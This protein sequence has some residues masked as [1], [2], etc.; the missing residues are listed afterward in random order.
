MKKIKKVLS[1]LLAVTLVFSSSAFNG[2]RVLAATTAT[3]NFYLDGELV[4]SETISDDIDTISIDSFTKPTTIEEEGEFTEGN[5][6][7]TVNSSV[8]VEDDT[9]W[10]PTG[11]SYYCLT[12]IGDDNELAYGDYSFSFCHRYIWNSPGT[13]TYTFVIATDSDGTGAVTIGDSTQISNWYSSLTEATGSGTISSDDVSDLSEYKYIG[14]Y[15]ATTNTYGIGGTSNNQTTTVQDLSCTFTMSETGS[16]E[17]SSEADEITVA[18]DADDYVFNYYYTTVSGDPITATA[19]Y[20]LNGTYLGSSDDDVQETYAGRTVTFTVPESLEYATFDHYTLDDTNYDEYTDTFEDLE[21]SITVYY[22]YTLEKCDVTVNYYMIDSDETETLISSEILSGLPGTYISVNIPQT[23]DDAKFAYY[24]IDGGDEITEYSTSVLVT[25]ENV[26]NYYFYN[27]YEVE[28]VN[29]QFELNSTYAWGYDITQ[30]DDAGYIFT[31]VNV[32]E[33]DPIATEVISIWNNDSDTYDYSLTYDIEDL[34]A[35]TYEVTI[36][37]Y[38]SVTS[39]STFTVT[40]ADETESAEISPEG[41]DDYYDDNWQSETITFTISEAGTVTISLSGTLATGD[42]L[43]VSGIEVWKIDAPLSAYEDVAEEYEI[44]Y[45][46]STFYN[47]DLDAYNAAADEAA[48]A[49]SGDTDTETTDISVSAS[50]SGGYN[51]QT[52]YYLLDEI[53]ETLTAGT[54]DYTYSYARVWN[55][56]TIQ[57]V[58]ATDSTGTAVKVIETLVSNVGWT[59]STVSNSGTVTLSEDDLSAANYTYVGIMISAGSNSWIGFT[60]GNTISFTFSSSTSDSEEDDT[61]ATK[62]PIYMI[63]AGWLESGDSVDSDG[64]IS[65]SYTDDDGNEV[66]IDLEPWNYYT[67]W[68]TDGD[69]IT[70]GTGDSVYSGLAA[71]TLDENGNISFNY[72]EG[73]LFTSD[74]TVKDIYTNVSIPYYKE[75]NTYKF[76]SDLYDVYWADDGTPSSDST[77]EYN[78]DKKIMGGESLGYLYE[79][80]FPFDGAD[81]TQATYNF[82][83]HTQLDFYLTEDGTIAGTDGEEMVW[84]F[85]GDDDV[86]VYVDGY[87]VLDIGGIHDAISAEINFAQ[88]TAEVAGEDCSERIQTVLD[89]ETA[90]YDTT[91]V[92]TIDVFYLERGQGESNCVISFNITP[93][94]TLTVEKNVSDTLLNTLTAGENTEFTFY[95]EKYNE[96]TDSWERV[97]E[98]LDYTLYSSDGTSNSQKTDSEGV[99]TLKNGESAQFVMA[100]TGLAEGDTVRAVEVKDE[101]DEFATS[102]EASDGVTTTAT[103][104]N[105]SSELGVSYDEESGIITVAIENASFNSTILAPWSESFVD[106]ST[107]TAGLTYYYDEESEDGRNYYFELSNTGDTD[108]ESGTLSRTV[109]GLSDDIAYDVSISFKS[110][111]LGYTGFTFTANDV[112]ESIISYSADE[113]EDIKLS[114]VYAEDGAISISISGSLPAGVTLAIDDLVIEAD[115]SD[116]TSGSTLEFICYNTAEV[117]LVDES[118]V[119]DYGKSVTVD[120]LE[121]DTIE[122]DSKYISWTDAVDSAGDSLGYVAGRATYGRYTY[123]TSA[124]TYNLQ[125]YISGIE[126]IIY[127]VGSYTSDVYAT[128]SIIPATTVY[129]EDDFGDGTNLNSTS[130]IVYTGN[131]TTTGTSETATTSQDTDFVNSEDANNYGYDNSYTDDST[132]SAGSA[133]V[134][135]GTGSTTAVFTFSGTGFDIISRTNDATGMITVKVHEGSDT[136]GNI[137]KTLA[138]VTTYY[139]GDLYQIPVINWSADTYGTYTVEVIV[140]SSNIFTSNTTFY[141][142]AIRIYNPIDPNGSDA[143]KAATA[144]ADDSEANAT[145]NEFRDLLIDASDLTGDDDTVNGIIYVDSC[146]TASTKTGGKVYVQYDSQLSLYEQIGPN[147][148]VYLEYGDAIGFGFVNNDSAEIAT[149]QIGAKAPNGSSTLKVVDITDG[150]SK[151]VILSTATDMYYDITEYCEAGHTVMITNADESVLSL[152]YI[153]VTYTSATTEDEPYSFKVS[154]TTSEEVI[155]ALSAILNDTVFDADTDDGSSDGIEFNEETNSV[156]LPDGYDSDLYE[157]LETPTKEG[158]IFAGWYFYDGTAY[159]P[160]QTVEG[161]YTL[162]ARWIDENVLSV[163]AQTVAGASADDEYT[164]VRFISTVDTLD[165]QSAGFIISYTVD[166]VEYKNTAAVS[167]VYTSVTASGTS[168][169]PSTFS[170]ESEYF[171]TYTIRNIPNANF[172]T[173]ITVLPYVVNEVG[174]TIYGVERTVTVNELLGVD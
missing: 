26:I 56:N 36:S 165:Y 107:F 84:D 16:G 166:G 99:F 49:S 81:D 100:V 55:G 2:I 104:G 32:G 141:L 125:S 146:E 34:E 78:F 59:E 164:T 77:L 174:T 170:S 124:I 37:V 22:Y 85:S 19:K 126:R 17:L 90:D 27:K 1:V 75:G 13:A 79:G 82:G 31:S 158:Y 35:G 69:T 43:Y 25:G 154:S 119:I 66:D 111:T 105:T 30:T 65:G 163:K 133:H 110:D 54:Y 94:N 41:Y 7:Y 9:T 97:F 18:S 151:E 93:V 169:L 139:A 11:T 162:Y 21:D 108:A 47:Y 109:T 53:G 106:T 64:T 87:L 98:E 48:G 72:A 138:V 29:G 156:T 24:T 33:T 172:D 52:E 144:Y 131:W 15:L 61:T 116:T 20:Y 57:L 167:K 95:V 68:N 148:E 128:L 63:G 153:K 127:G 160:E 40:G 103:S 101:D 10:T 114:D 23:A 122:D 83:Q 120:V 129:Y 113:W 92:H 5:Y 45:F 91:E 121:N 12:Y 89:T 38:G 136:S 130:G 157:D 115:L 137:V 135:D 39:A 88:L 71:D 168:L 6:S 70:L 96:D 173:E 4:A 74:T 3:A 143:E 50:D 171:I 142:D 149:V 62:Q 8:T 46:D 117:T 80:Y 140:N 28:L 134:V 76:D 51:A 145:V 73:G 42:W 150:E 112:S 147:N 155:T 14:I 132:L 44:F 152:T 159:D 118:I 161:S 60:A 86:W 58:L 102:W 67:G 123:D